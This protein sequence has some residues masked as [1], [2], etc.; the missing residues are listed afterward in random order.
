MKRDSNKLI[1]E[2]SAILKKHE[3]MDMDISELV[4][5]IDDLEADN[6]TGIADTIY[7]SFLFGVAVGYRICK[8]RSRKEKAE[9]D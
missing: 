4:N 8:N 1:E 7:H 3:R 6:D 2:G 5:L 9:E